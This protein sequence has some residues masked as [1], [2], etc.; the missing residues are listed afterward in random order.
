MPTYEYI[1]ESCG[2]EFEKFQSITAGHL[3][4]CPKCGEFRLKRKIGKGSGIIFHGSGF[5]ETDYRSEGY[6]AEARKDSTSETTA[7]SSAAK[8]PCGGCCAK[9][10]S[11]SKGKA[12]KKD[13]K[14]S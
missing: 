12:S 5:Y 6:K 7:G 2:F 4:K 9:K 11:P 14:A 10:S 8:A 1:C 3:R 13:R